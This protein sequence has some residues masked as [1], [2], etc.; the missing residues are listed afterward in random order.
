MITVLSFLRPFF[1]SCFTVKQDLFA[2]S[3]VEYTDCISQRGKTH[4]SNECP[5]YDT[6]QSDVEVPVMLEF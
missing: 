6:K 5:R 1:I 3:A 2:Q 4:A